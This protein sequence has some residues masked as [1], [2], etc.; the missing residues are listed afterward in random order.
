MGLRLGT[1]LRKEPRFFFSF[2]IFEERGGAMSHNTEFPSESR[3]DL[4]LDASCNRLFT[5]GR[6]ANGDFLPLMNNEQK[7]N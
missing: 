2:L 7:K 3:K 5:V 1:K 6:N 4:R